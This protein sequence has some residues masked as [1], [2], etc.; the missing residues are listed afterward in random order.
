MSVS[1]LSSEFTVIVDVGE[2]IEGNMKG[3]EA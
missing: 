2:I 3:V 1:K